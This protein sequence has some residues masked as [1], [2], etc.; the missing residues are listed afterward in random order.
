[1]LVIE[2]FRTTLEYISSV[3]CHDL[4]FESPLDKKLTMFSH[5][6]KISQV[7]GAL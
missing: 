1:M 3:G 6:S 7:S 2:K 5:N 4:N